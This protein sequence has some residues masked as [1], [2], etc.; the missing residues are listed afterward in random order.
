LVKT[1][2][3]KGLHVVLPLARRNTW[4]ETKTF[5]HGIAVQMERRFPERFVSVASKARRTG[6][7]FVDY[8]RNSR[9]ATA[10]APYS[11]RAR[12]GA[13]VAMP[14]AWEELD[15]KRPADFTLE[16]ADKYLTTR[17]DPWSEYSTLRQTITVKMRSSVS[18]A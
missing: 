9:G 8:L 1:T 13:T 12:L 5:A 10:V 18:A 4:D 11:L 3:G 15:T 16:T 2:G 7:I 14:I 17:S 6:K